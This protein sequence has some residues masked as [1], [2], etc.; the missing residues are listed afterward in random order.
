MAGAGEVHGRS[1]RELTGGGDEVAALIKAEALDALHLM[2]GARE[3]AVEVLAQGH[4]I[5]R[6]ERYGLTWINRLVRVRARKRRGNGMSSERSA[7]GEI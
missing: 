5:P 4:P 3:I 7:E 1:P 2:V 6:H